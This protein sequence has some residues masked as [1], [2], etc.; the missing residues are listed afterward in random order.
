MFIIPLLHR[1]I[2]ETIAR[3]LSLQAALTL[4][5]QCQVEQRVVDRIRR[6]FV[7][8]KNEDES[9]AEDLVVGE[10]ACGVALR[11]GVGG[12]AGVAEECA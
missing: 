9:I 6:S 1:L 11:E 5:M 12:C 4:R 8:C 3:Q 7:S 10:R 2:H